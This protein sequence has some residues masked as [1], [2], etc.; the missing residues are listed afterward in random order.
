M[1][2][3]EKLSR[4]ILFAMF[5]WSLMIPATLSA[6]NSRQIKLAR[7]FINGFGT[8]SASLVIEGENLGPAALVSI[9]TAGGHFVALDLV[10]S[11]PT[12]LDARLGYPTPVRTSWKCRWGTAARRAIKSTSRSAAGA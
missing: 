3:V 8:P 1:R 10:S 11:S 6:Q 4:P 2:R 7:A 5:L 12:Q 9:G